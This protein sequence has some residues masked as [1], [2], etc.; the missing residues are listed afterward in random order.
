MPHLG[1]LWLAIGKHDVQTVQEIIK[2]NPELINKP[3]FNAESKTPLHKAAYEG[4]Y[5]I[6]KILIDNGAE[7]NARDKFDETSLHEAARYG[8][9]EI[10]KLLVEHN[11]DINALNKDNKTPLFAS[12]EVY[13]AGTSQ[14]VIKVLLDAGA[15]I[16]MTIFEAARIGDTK[17]VEQM[18]KKNPE[19]INSRDISWEDFT[20]LLHATDTKSV[21]MVELLLSKGADINAHDTCGHTPLL[22]AMENCDDDELIELFKAWGAAESEDGWHV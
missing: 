12:T 4:H 19:L 3:N 13:D 21:D 8:K 9:T 15:G 10:V 18:L 1:D 22:L 7:I 14:D 16:T 6:A 20:P 5:A 11:A 17:R 2:N